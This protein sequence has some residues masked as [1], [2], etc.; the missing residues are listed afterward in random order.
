LKKIALAMPT[1]LKQ[2]KAG[3]ALSDK[4]YDMYGQAVMEAV[5]NA[6]RMPKDQWPI[7]P[8]HQSPR[9]PR[10]VPARVKALRAWRDAKAE[11]LDLNEAL[12]FNRALIKAI[13]TDNPATKASL[14]K[15]D[16][17]HQWQVDAF[18][19]EILAVLK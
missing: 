3:G 12:L 15:V 18:G 4:Q 16:G 10:K 13:A 11:E 2:L 19:D 9:V 14:A 1:S 7:Y 5:R 6:R 17:I 8:R